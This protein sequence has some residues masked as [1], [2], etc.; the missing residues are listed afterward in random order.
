M[1]NSNSRVHSVLVLAC[2][3]SVACKRGIGQ[4]ITDH[5]KDLALVYAGGAIFLKGEMI[6]HLMKEM[7]HEF[8]REAIWE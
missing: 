7:N 4:F 1:D 6:S 3:F 5:Y 8:G 2:H